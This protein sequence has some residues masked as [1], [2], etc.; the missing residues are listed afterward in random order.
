M[1]VLRGRCS[2]A[3][4]SRSAAVACM[5]ECVSTSTS[6]SHALPRWDGEAHAEAVERRRESAVVECFV[7]GQQSSAWRVQ[8]DDVPG[9]FIGYALL[10]RA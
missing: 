5:L 8:A 9:R 10:L 7:S 3:H 6:G 4:A 1:R 2:D